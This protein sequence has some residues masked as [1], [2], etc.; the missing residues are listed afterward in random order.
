MSIRLYS[1]LSRRLEELPPPPGPIRMY[2]CGS[3]VYARVHVG[4]SRPFVL[5]MWLRRWLR[6]RGYDVTLVHNITDV[7]D[8]VYEEAGKLGKGQPRARR[9][10]DA[11][12][13]RR[14]PTDLGLGRPDVEPRA[15]E[16]IPEIIAFIEALV[17]DGKAYES[18]GSVYFRVA[19]YPDY[20][21]LSGA[22]LED[23]V[24]QEPNPAKE[25]ERDFALWKAQK[26]HEDAA[27]DSPWGPGRPGWHIECSAMAE[28]HLGPEFEI[29]GG[30]LDLR[31][32]HHE[33]EL[34][35]SRSRGYPF[36]HVWLHNGMLE[37]GDEKMSKS[38]GNVVTLRN[39]LDTWG[40]ETLLLYHMSGH[41]RKPVDF[42][43][44]SLE[45]VRTQLAGFREA[46]CAA[47]AGGGRLGA[48]R[49]GARGRLQHA[50]GARA[51]PRVGFARGAGRARA[52]A[53]PVRAADRVRGAGGDR[54]AARAARGGSRREGL[55]GCGR[56]ARRDRGGRL[57]GHRSLGRHRRLAAAVTQAAE[58][59]YGRRAVREALRGRREVLELLA[60]ERAAREDWERKPKI[61][62]EKTLTELA[63]TRDHQGVVARVEPFRYAD[64]YELAAG[65]A[66][67]RR[68]RPGHRPAQPRRGDPERRGGR[69]HRHRPARR[70]LG[71]G[72][73][74][75]R[76][77]VG[78]GG[79][80]PA[81]RGRHQPLAVPEGDQGAAALGLCGGRGRD[82]HVPG[83]TCPGD[84]TLVFGA[85]GKGLRPLVRKTC[86]AA[87]S[88][89]LAGQVES[90]N[91]S[92]AAAVLLYEARR[93]R[94]A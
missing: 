88:I 43:D 12:V 5:A 7:D 34:A 71:A 10:G 69:R 64:A 13:S 9:G 67:D 4:N 78:R 53:R 15:S 76:P 74:G 40:R 57:G 1:T 30:G 21:Q 89:P 39:V 2:V 32:P 3:T 81:G 79:R 86:D 58:L 18:Q 20:G 77:G 62:P 82:A 47:G 38:L 19:A 31:F 93:Q 63:G 50:G 37:L 26:P 92:V 52:R 54:G 27:W 90:L 66:A 65:R 29:H 60:T 49:G 72:D 94:D 61:V 42:T 11:V 8:K 70:Q 23:M 45:S 68:A 85:E 25:D 35:Q 56:G 83:A 17:A 55:G 14:T 33:N 24:A 75:G 44:E 87:V 16:T 59:V 48:A 41:W 84:L 36:A 46:A 80:A 6:S 73:A 91:V 22:R 28:K 51:P